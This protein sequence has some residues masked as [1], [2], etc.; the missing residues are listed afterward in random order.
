[1]AEELPKQEKKTLVDLLARNISGN[2][3]DVNDSIVNDVQT[4]AAKMDR[5]PEELKVAG[6]FSD[7]DNLQVND[8]VGNDADVL[9]ANSANNEKGQIYESQISGGVTHQ[10]S[11]SSS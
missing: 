1:M 11:L 2:S 5:I 3:C 6:R 4:P 7:K 10:S 9:S 8:D